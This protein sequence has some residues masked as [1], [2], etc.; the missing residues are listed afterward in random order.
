MARQSKVIRRSLVAGFIGNYELRIS[1]GFRVSIPPSF[2]GRLGTSLVITKGL[3]GNLYIFSPKEWEKILKPIMDRSLFN[4]NVRYMLRYLFSQ[5]FELQID[6]LGRIVLPSQL[7]AIDGLDLKVG[8]ILVAAGMYRWIE[9]WP[10]KSWQSNMKQVAKKV[11][12]LSD[13]IAEL[14]DK[15]LQE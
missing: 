15:T 10:L 2:K 1:N 3:E 14:E 9:L 4:R 13:L 12:S 6:K 7:R 11:D 8:D 5:A